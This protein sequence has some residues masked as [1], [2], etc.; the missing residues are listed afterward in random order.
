MTSI[1]LPGQVDPFAMA[2]D[3]AY[4]AFP[5]RIPITLEEEVTAAVIEWYRVRGQPVPAEELA[6][7]RGIDA[8][9][10]REWET[11]QK[12]AGPVEEKPA[13]GTPEF[14]KQFWAKK[15]AKE[16]E[17]KARTESGG[18]A[19]H[20]PAVAKPKKKTLSKVAPGPQKS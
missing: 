11:I 8:A 16:A 18:E 1:L 3:V 17:L 9:Q 13:Y 14:W 7:C 6:A 2:H 4:A 19:P 12:T 20:A 5:E 10:Q 15:R